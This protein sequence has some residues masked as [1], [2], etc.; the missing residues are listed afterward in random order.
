MIFTSNYAR[1]GENPNAVAISVRPPAWYTGRCFPSL[2]PTWQMVN[3]VRRGKI[4]HDQYDVL[5]FDLLKK[6][7]LDPHKIVEELGEDAVLLCYESPNQRC[8]RRLVAAWIKEHTGIDVPEKFL[9]DSENKL[10]KDVF[11]F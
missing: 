7:K 3:D 9:Y 8:H 6:R 4:T 11:E 10:L 2:A 5:Y 1:D